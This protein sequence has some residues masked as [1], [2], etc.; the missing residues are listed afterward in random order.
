MGFDMQETGRYIKQYRK[1]A[2][3]TQ[4]ELA[5][6][7]GISTMSIRR[8]E[9]GE[10]IASKDMIQRI[11][12]ALG[13]SEFDLLGLEGLKTPTEDWDTLLLQKLWAVGHNIEHVAGLRNYIFL[14]YPDGDLEVTVAELKELDRITNEFLLIELQALR[15]RHPERFTPKPENR[16]FAQMLIQARQANQDAPLSDEPETPPEDK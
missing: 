1:V 8:Y 16:I 11:A 14:K 15:D 9:G 3:L 6:K 13:V 2:G 4:E 5:Q 12:D 10:R 7:V